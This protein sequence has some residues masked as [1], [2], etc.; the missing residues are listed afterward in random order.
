MSTVITF[1]APDV[2]QVIARARTLEKTLSARD[3][4]LKNATQTI[5]KLQGTVA[6]CEQGRAQE[7]TALRSQLAAAGERAGSLEA[8]LQA[9]QATLAQSAN[10]YNALT[11]NMT[12]REASVNELVARARA[13]EQRAA[14]S[15]A[16]LAQLGEELAVA[17]QGASNRN[18][19]TQTLTE[20][21]RATEARVAELEAQAEA[22]RRNAG[23]LSSERNS[24]SKRLNN[25]NARARDTSA[26][27][28]AAEARIGELQA[29]LSA[30]QARVGELEADVSSAQGALQAARA[31]LEQW[32]AAKNANAQRIANANVAQK[33]A[34]VDLRSKSEQIS[35]LGGQIVG[36][37]AARE[38]LEG[39]L[40]ESKS[41]L[42]LLRQQLSEAR[43]DA[44]ARARAMG[45]LQGRYDELEARVK[46]ASN[47]VNRERSKWRADEEALRGELA[48]AQRRLQ[49]Q[50]AARQS[51]NAA[52]EQLAE[53]LKNAAALSHTCQ[54]LRPTLDAARRLPVSKMEFA[55]NEA[56]K[57]FSTEQYKR[58]GIMWEQHNKVLKG[59][60]HV[61]KGLATATGTENVTARANNAGNAVTANLPLPLPTSTAMPLS[62]R[63]TYARGRAR[64]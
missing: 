9:H 22:M 42:E 46:N 10:R 4:A 55:V 39:Q 48:A 11:R 53:Q 24:L 20:R 15:D 33:K 51:A 56:V 28:Q 61:L 29:A 40:S 16:R 6:S 7:V 5:S 52:R 12:Q 13:A 3:A 21:L 23:A 8:T 44:T 41:A 14:D 58:T 57:Y 37:Q 25:F 19:Q 27:A 18:T 45:D 60:L 54:L 30:A 49:E 31:Q 59:M 36:L 64:R 63:P 2:G 62:A 50:N 17:R 32:T 1:R 35:Q 26:S 34:F 43:N 47:G 38:Q